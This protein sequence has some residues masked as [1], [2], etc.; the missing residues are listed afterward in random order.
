MLMTL[1]M[2]IPGLAAVSL[3]PKAKDA[4]KEE[5]LRNSQFREAQASLQEK[6]RV[7]EKRYEQRQAARANAIEA[8]A[9]ELANRQRVVVIRSGAASPVPNQEASMM[10]AESLVLPAVLAA[11]GCGFL[12]FRHYR[13]HQRVETVR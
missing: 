4:A 7:G 5:Q 8:M 9:A 3:G 11:L 1:A 10:W 6:L 12:G 2:A 13:S